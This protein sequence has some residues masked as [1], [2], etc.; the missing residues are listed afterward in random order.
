MMN[1]QARPGASRARRAGEELREGV[2]YT[3]S[4]PPVR[5][6]I[7]IV[8]MI[9]LFGVSVGTLI[10]AWA[11]KILHGN[12][13]TNGLLQSAR[14]V[15]AVGS[16]L[17]LAALGGSIPRG[18]LLTLGTFAL[19][20]TILAFA[21]VGSAP[22]SLLVMAVVGA[23]MILIM[24]LANAM[25]QSQVPDALRGRVMSIYSL[26]FFGAMPLGALGVGAIA[27]RLS[28]P[29]AVMLNAVVLLVFAAAMRISAPWLRST[30]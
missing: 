4:H 20:L 10:P 17:L 28:E 12:A 8:G 1:L 13:T 7:V 25:V 22:L 3:L 18:R 11:V 23:A 30:E 27:E 9:S 16:A 21:A 29:R 14:G 6:L 19:P 15:G 24:N 5:T 2:L 26:G